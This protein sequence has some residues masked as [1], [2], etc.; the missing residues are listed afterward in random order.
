M[1]PPIFM[2]LRWAIDN[3]SPAQPSHA[4]H[5]QRAMPYPSKK[6]SPG[7]HRGLSAHEDCLGSRNSRQRTKLIASVPREQVSILRQSDRYRFARLGR[8]HRDGDNKR[9]CPVTPSNW[10]RAMLPAEP[11]RCSRPQNAKGYWKGCLVSGCYFV[12]AGW[13]CFEPYLR[14]P[15]H[16]R[17]PSLLIGRSQQRSGASG[18]VCGRA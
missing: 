4:V 8:H 14:Q 17:G 9:S 18:R 7:F 5:H 10:Y 2:M 16:L 11:C 12:E 1:R 6:K 13:V 15:V 3:I